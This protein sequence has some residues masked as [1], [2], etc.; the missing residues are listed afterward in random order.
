MNFAKLKRLCLWTANEGI[1]TEC[2]RWTARHKDITDCE[3]GHRG[4]EG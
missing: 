4:D 1:H 3:E 2:W